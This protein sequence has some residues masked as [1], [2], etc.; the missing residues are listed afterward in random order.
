MV[1]YR[2]VCSCGK[3]TYEGV[4]D[5]A[6]Y[7]ETDYVMTFLMGLKESSAPIRSKLLLMEPELMT[8][9]VFSLVDQR[10]IKNSSTC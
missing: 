10:A 3:C 1:S 7:F 2:P 5:L 4:K 9:R 8:N 6:T